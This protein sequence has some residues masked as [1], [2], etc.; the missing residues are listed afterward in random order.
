MSANI[1]T[2][3]LLPAAKMR[4][5]VNFLLFLLWITDAYL[6]PPW[7]IH[8]ID[9]DRYVLEKKD[10]HN[11]FYLHNGTNTKPLG[12]GKVAVH[13]TLTSNPKRKNKSPAGKLDRRAIILL[14]LLLSGD[15]ELNPGPLTKEQQLSS[16]TLE[17]TDIYDA[18]AATK[19][20]QVTETTEDC[21]TPGSVHE[22]YANNNSFPLIRIELY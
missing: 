3:L 1:V 15:V 5:L 6:N 10:S 21:T 7:T 13:L 8:Q 16:Q 4:I 14:F 19:N 11:E 9:K 18:D 20:L 17:N 12:F 22:S 2:F